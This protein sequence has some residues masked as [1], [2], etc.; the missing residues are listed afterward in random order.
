[1]WLAW[2]LV[3]DPAPRRAGALFHY[4]MLY[5]AALFVAMAANAVA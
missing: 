5:L 3:R 4:S 1:V 2:R